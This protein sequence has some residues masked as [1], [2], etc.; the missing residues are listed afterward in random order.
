M[1]RLTIASV[2]VAVLLAP[3]QMHAAEKKTVGAILAISGSVLMLSAFNYKGGQCPAGYST[4]TIENLPTQCVFISASGDSD[5]RNA[6]TSI[7]YQRPGLMWSGLGAATTG[8][9]LMLLPTRAAEVVDVSVTPIGW[10][11]STTFGF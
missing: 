6:T 1:Q 9:V 11:A 3:V 8:I 7:S 10:L 5:V 2:L 4:H